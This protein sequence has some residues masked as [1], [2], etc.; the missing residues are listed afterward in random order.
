MW[1]QILH[2]DIKSSNCL[3][4]RTLTCKIA[5]VGIAKAMSG[6]GVELTQARTTCLGIRGE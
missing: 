2:M 3:L 1:A 5:D 4:T 6:N